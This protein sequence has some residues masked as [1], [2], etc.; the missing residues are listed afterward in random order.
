VKIE[1]ADDEKRAD[2]HADGESMPMQMAG[3]DATGIG[4]NPGITEAP[5]PEAMKPPPAS[6]SL[7]SRV[8]EIGTVS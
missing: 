7:V 3:P 1:A 4:A 8:S 6:R 2:A 5:S